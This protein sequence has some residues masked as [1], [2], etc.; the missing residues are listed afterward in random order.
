MALVGVAAFGTAIYAAQPASGNSAELHGRV[1]GDIRPVA[2]G[3]VED[4][5]AACMARVPKDATAGQRMM[6]KQSCDRDSE[7]RKSI[8]AVPG[9]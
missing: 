9:R 4:N 1:T 2:S 8:E 6:A 7:N 5:Q 3:A